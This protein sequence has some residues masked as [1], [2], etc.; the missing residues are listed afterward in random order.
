MPVIGVRSSWLMLARN[1]LFARATASAASFSQTKRLSCLFR[2]AKRLLGPLTLGDVNQCNAALLSG[3]GGHCLD[4]HAERGI[5]L[6]QERHLA[7]LFGRTCKD[8][9][10][11]SGEDRGGSLRYEMLEAPAD[12]P[13]A[14]DPHEAGASE[15]SCG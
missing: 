8:L 14:L 12:Q 2:L 4:L 13:G 9:S 10:K 15:V 3:C 1:W 7:R 6:F 5:P 11:E